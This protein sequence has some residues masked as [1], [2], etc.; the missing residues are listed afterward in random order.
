MASTLK[1]IFEM[2]NSIEM[3]K[4][5]ESKLIFEF[6]NYGTVYYKGLYTQ[7]LIESF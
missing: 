2:K 6:P 4:I 3:P 5:F 1:K 7:G